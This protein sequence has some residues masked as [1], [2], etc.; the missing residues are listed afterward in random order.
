MRFR[1][2]RALALAAIGATMAASCGGGVHVDY[3]ECPP[4]P[5]RPRGAKTC[6]FEATCGYGT[7]IGVGTSSLDA[8]NF[9]SC[10]FG[11]LETPGA[12][13]EVP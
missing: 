6:D 9:V 5:F 12:T 8:C 7:P 4:A 2:A 10:D 13:N 11:R 1:L 3:H